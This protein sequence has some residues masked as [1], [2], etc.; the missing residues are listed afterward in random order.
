MATANNDPLVI[1]IQSLDRANK[2]VVR[3]RDVPVRTSNS[4]CKRPVTGANYPTYRR[5]CHRARAAA[6]GQSRA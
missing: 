5:P 4:T 2:A 3:I 6:V 1:T